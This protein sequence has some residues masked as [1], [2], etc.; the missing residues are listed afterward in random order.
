MGKLTS[1]GESLRDSPTLTRA[2][3]QNVTLITGAEIDIGTV[4]LP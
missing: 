2:L 4:I 3:V 1:S